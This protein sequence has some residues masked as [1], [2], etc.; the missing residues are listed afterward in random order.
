MKGI[1]LLVLFMITFLF[2]TSMAQLQT[3]GE[4]GTF[5]FSTN[6]VSFRTLTTSND[7]PTYAGTESLEESL[8]FIVHYTQEGMEAVTQAYACSVKTYAE[9]SWDFE[10]TQLGWRNPPIDGGRGGDNRYD[11]YIKSISGAKG[12][13]DPEPEY[14]GSNEW[15]SSYIQI[16]T[17]LDIESNLKATI[18]HEFNHACQFAYTYKDGLSIAENWFYESTATWIQT[19]VFPEV[20]DEM[21]FFNPSYNIYN[22]LNHPEIR[23]NYYGPSENTDDK[24]I[25]ANFVFPK[26]FAEWLND[27]DVI[28]KI[29]SRK[30]DITNASPTLDDIDF[31]LSNFYNTNITEGLRNYAVWRYFTGSRDDGLHFHNAILFPEV[32]LED[33]RG[34]GIIAYN[35]LNQIYGPGG[36]R[37]IPYS[38][39]VDLNY[40]VNVVVGDDMAAS[41]I[42][43]GFPD[44][45]YA[46][47][48]PISYTNGHGTGQTNCR[49]IEK[50]S[51]IFVPV[52]LDY[53]LSNQSTFNT[54]ALS[55]RAVKFTNENS[56][57]NNI[58]GQLLIDNNSSL[59][60]NS[61]TR[62]SLSLTPNHN[63][64]TLNE[65]LLI[66]NQTQKHNNWNNDKS[67]FFTGHNF[68]VLSTTKN[69]K[70]KFENIKYS[71]IEAR[72]EGEVIPDKGNFTFQ[73]PW[74]MLNDGSQPGN[75][76]WISCT[77]FYEPTGKQGAAEKGVFLNQNPQYQIGIPN[78][79][80]KITSPQPIFLNGRTH[81]FYFQ[82]WTGTN[83]NFKY[84][85]ELET[86]LVFT[87]DNAVATANYKGHFLSNSS[88][89]S[90]YNGQRKIVRDRNG[91]YHMV[92]HSMNA[93]W[94]SKSLTTNLSGA[95][96]PEIK[97]IENGAEIFTNPS[98]DVNTVTHMNYR[99]DYLKVAFEFS[100]GVSGSA[101]IGVILID[102]NTG[103]VQVLGDV[104]ISNDYYGN[105]KPVVASFDN[106]V[107][108]IYKESATSN[109][110]YLRYYLDGSNWIGLTGSL[111]GSSAS[112][113]N[114]TVSANNKP[115]EYL[116][117]R[118][119]I[120]W[121]EGST[122][123]K[124][125]YSETAGR[126]NMIEPRT[127]STVQLTSFG[128]GN[129]YNTNPSIID[130]N[131]GARVVWHGTRV[132]GGQVI[133]DRL[134]FRDAT[135]GGFW[136]F[137]SN[138]GSPVINKKDDNTAYILA[139]SQNDGTQGCFADNT[140]SQIHDL[141]I[142]GKDMQLCN[143]SSF[144]SMFVTSFTN[145]TSPYFFK[146]SN[147]I[148]SLYTIAK[149]NIAGINKGRE[150][151][152]AKGSGE[153]YFT[154]GDV[155]VNGENISFKTL[156]DS[157]TVISV[158]DINNNVRTIP[159]A[160]SDNSQFNYS[161]QYGITDSAEVVNSLSVNDVVSFRV[162]I[163]DEATN[164]VLGV[165]DNVSFT[166]QHALPYENFSYQV[167]TEGIGNRTV[168]LRLVTSATEGCSFSLAN[169]LDN[170]N[171]IAKRA[172]NQ[173]SFKSAAVIKDYALAQNYPNPFNPATI[174]TY[175][176]PKSGSV[177]LKIYDMLGK[178]VKTLVNEQKE[179]GR[180]TVQFDASSLASGMYVYQLRAND[181]TSTK[182]MLLLK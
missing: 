71:K 54:T 175:Q 118:V 121:Q 171:I 4:C 30:G 39:G 127:F 46:Q 60:I 14:S 161:V 48:I 147:D 120:A 19:L 41:V 115:Y 75:N 94:Y 106:E 59:Q 172:I 61:G 145:T 18:A 16:N 2:K 133:A 3:D 146:Q 29:W 34:S 28:Q 15:S 97:L 70:S 110:K 119:H 107:F 157:F 67:N 170:Q 173:I 182:K 43:Y 109:L 179:M 17:N 168:Y 108:V 49:A 102:I 8:H 33:T 152:V 125:Q 76:Y 154:I 176:L 174:I 129:T 134:S 44:S 81:T 85:N 156:P 159:F 166:K 50:N 68:D 103:T 169:L 52:C 6:P 151:V 104:P 140:L 101:G 40:S 128:S 131:G 112:S 7:R 32:E 114:P 57:V 84:P 74:Y 87:N 63:V 5:K 150:G 56:D 135:G 91:I 36:T 73:D 23:V 35:T 31:V 165:F 160:I 123:I 153:L 116:N 99:D 47:K 62:I 45:S 177:T 20:H 155:N 149:A 132:I 21:R 117:N 130:L 137:G 10:C 138:V 100:S 64:K 178:E 77:A 9:Y 26:F 80:A 113:I 1:F 51:F 82:N 96:A 105:A 126:T 180:Y 66:S 88:T 24:Y 72:L 111:S 136:H 53:N 22:P 139:W 83:V 141:Q 142:T 78:Y 181:Y 163:V 89:A 148:Q 11:I 69:I 37:F 162:E 90:A 167:S 92:Y 65:R 93:L 164:E 13:A 55:S 58:G 12:E 25:Y 86:P 27:N 124:Y 158:N 42:E 122:Y 95:W 98:I 144:S 79:S 38:S 143:G